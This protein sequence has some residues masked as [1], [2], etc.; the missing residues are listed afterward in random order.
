MND[1]FH[2]SAYNKTCTGTISL[3]ETQSILGRLDCID[4]RVLNPLLH[5]L[6]GPGGETHETSL[7][8]LYVC[9]L[10][11]SLLGRYSIDILKFTLESQMKT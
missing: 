5:I 1:T 8:C 4:S 10:G 9:G 7:R 11:G 3:D 6:V 2:G